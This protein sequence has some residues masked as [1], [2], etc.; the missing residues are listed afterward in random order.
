MTNEQR[1]LLQAIV[2]RADQCSKY[3]RVC[4]KRDA[5]GNDVFVESII[6]LMAWTLIR[7]FFLV[8]GTKLRE[9]ASAWLFAQV[10]EESGLCELCGKLKNFTDEC[11]VC[12]RGDEI[13]AECQ[14]E[15]EEEDR[16]CDM[17]DLM[18][19]PT[20]GPIS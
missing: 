14:A 17:M 4:L 9:Q 11:N 16:L 2:R 8:C 7:T 18:E 5:E 15:F 3:A 12:G 19:T 1:H 20:R 10:C 13:C 6:A